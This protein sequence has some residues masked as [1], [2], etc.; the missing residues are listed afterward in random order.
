MQLHVNAIMKND[1]FILQETIVQ[2]KYQLLIVDL[3][4]TSVWK[5]RVLPLIKADIASFNSLKI[6]LAVYHQA[7][8]CNMLEVMLYQYTAIK[9][10]KNLLI[11]II[12]YCY[13]KITPQIAKSVQKR[14]KQ[15][16]NS[17]ADEPQL[18]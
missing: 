8:V 9:E 14:V 17:K 16:Q 10:S 2:D 13:K 15:R 5:K 7:V 4:V 1:Q 6:Y 11:E 3:L 12:D 18:T